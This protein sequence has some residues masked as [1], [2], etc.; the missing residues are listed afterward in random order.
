[1]FKPLGF[2]SIAVHKTMQ[3]CI[4]VGDIHQVGCDL[5]CP[6]SVAHLVL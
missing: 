1:M 3:I 4:K 6:V 5:F 2:G